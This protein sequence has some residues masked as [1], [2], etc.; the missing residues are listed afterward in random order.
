MTDTLTVPVVDYT[1]DEHAHPER[2]TA[3]HW[4]GYRV[5]DGQSLL[6]LSGV[7]LVDLTG[8]PQWSRKVVL[9]QPRL[10][11]AIGLLHLPAPKPNHYW[12]MHPT[13]WILFAAPASMENLK[14]AFNAGWAIDCFRTAIA[15][16]TKL[17]NDFPLYLDTAVRDTDGKL[18]RVAYHIR[19]LGDM[20]QAESVPIN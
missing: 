18:W 15:P 10:D 11:R 1:I 19:V 3:L 14:E 5:A 17:C 9:L 8:A 16:E 12:Y 13:M 2:F 6:E 7:A 20:L 4:M